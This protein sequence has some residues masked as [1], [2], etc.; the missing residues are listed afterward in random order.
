M[1]RVSRLLDVDLFAL[2]LDSWSFVG[3]RVVLRLSK[4]TGRTLVRFLNVEETTLV[5][6]SIA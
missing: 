6:G 4:I 5:T 3:F 2:C 1:P